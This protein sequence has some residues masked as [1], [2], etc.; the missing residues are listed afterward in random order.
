MGM[1][2]VYSRDDGGWYT[3]VY[4]TETGED[5]HVTK[6]YATRAEARAAGRRWCKTQCHDTSAPAQSGKGE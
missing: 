4:S 1:Y 6:V 3:E 2:T 5:L